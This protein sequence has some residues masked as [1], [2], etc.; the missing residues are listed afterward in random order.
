MNIDSHSEGQNIFEIKEFN[1]NSFKDAC[2]LVFRKVDYEEH[3]NKMM[4]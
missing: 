2:E 3:Y 4:K 1:Y